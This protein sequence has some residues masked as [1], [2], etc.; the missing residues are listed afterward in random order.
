M[1]NANEIKKRFFGEFY[2]PI[3]FATLALEYIDLVIGEKWWLSGNYRLWDMAAG[4]GNLEYY[5]PKEAHRYCYLSTLYSEDVEKCKQL[6]PTANCF[7]YDYLNDDVDNLENLAGFGNPQGLKMSQKLISDLQNPDIKWIILINP[8]FATSQTAGANSESK[9]GVSDTKIRKLMHSNNLGE[10]SRELFSQFIF[11]INKEFVNKSAYLCLF[12]K[13]KYLNASNDQKLRDN[14]FNYTFEKGFIFSSANFAETSRSSQFP[15]GFLIWNLNKYLKINEQKIELDILNEKAELIDKKTII[16]ENK[17]KFLNNWIKRPP[18]TIKFP[19]VCSAITLKPDNKDKR[20]RIS[21]G[22]LASLM[23]AGNNLQCQNQTALFSM[24]SASAGA[25][26]VTPDNFDKAMVIHAVRRI[27]KATWINDRDQF[28]QPTGE[29]TDKF[30]SDCVV[31]S[32]F[33]KSNETV[34]LRNINYEN[35]I[36]QINNHFFPF[37]ISELDF[38]IKP[39]KQLQA[40]KRVLFEN[41]VITDEDRFVAKWLQNKNLSEESK[42]LLHKGKEIY[43]YYFVNIHLLHLEK[44][45]IETWDAGWWQIRNS[46]IDKFLIGNLFLE[47]KILHKKLSEKLITQIINYKFVAQ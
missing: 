12:S 46:L 47:M 20:D 1:Q 37:L 5:L 30:I 22:F 27:P 31:W 8:P 45:K 29:L 10:V 11:R 43:Q 3:N 15:V 35:N 28:L 33:S 34:A 16:I 7:Q 6:F 24:P 36:Y 41:Q 23:C 38:Q 19:P 40:A 18:A 9:Q 2:T 21:E 32:I 4:T 13:I 39:A 17:N 26:S 44:F 25:F 14:L 42:K